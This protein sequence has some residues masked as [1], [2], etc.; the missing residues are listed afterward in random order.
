MEGEDEPAEIAALKRD[1]QTMATSF[2]QGGQWLAQGM[3]GSWE[4]ARPLLQIPALADILGERHR[5][6]ANDWPA[7]NMQSLILLD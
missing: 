3:R 7:A 4:A 5:I 6:T 1:L 2:E